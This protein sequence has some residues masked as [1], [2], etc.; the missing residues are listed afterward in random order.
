[1]FYYFFLSCFST[2]FEVP[3]AFCCFDIMPVFK[4]VYKIYISSKWLV[5][6]H[7]RCAHF[8]RLFFVRIPKPLAGVHHADIGNIL[9]S[10]DSETLL[11]E[12]V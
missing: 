7:S 6:Q 5:L 9:L 2:F 12:N 10:L 1:M 8:K 4:P 3:V 11:V